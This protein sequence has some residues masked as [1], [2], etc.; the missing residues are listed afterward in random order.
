MHAPEATQR[1]WFELGALGQPTVGPGATKLGRSRPQMAKSAKYWMSH[2]TLL[3][4]S[5][6]SFCL[7]RPPLH[8][9]SQFPLLRLLPSF[10]F[11]LPQNHHQPLSRIQSCPLLYLKTPRPPHHTNLIAAYAK[12]IGTVPSQTFNS[13]VTRGHPETPYYSL[14]IGDRTCRLARVVGGGTER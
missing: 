10:P 14:R 3:L 7:F 1:S 11:S 6:P 5:R 8:R 2:V 12:R 4:R 13:T 9:S